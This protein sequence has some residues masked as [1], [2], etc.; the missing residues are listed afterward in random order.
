MPV[1]N[2]RRTA[3]RELSKK[4]VHFTRKN[5]D[6]WVYWTSGYKTMDHYTIG[7][8]LHSMGFIVRT[9]DFDQICGKTRSEFKIR[10]GK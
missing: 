6:T 9:E 5:E 10:G 8:Y 3:L 7:E 1:L 4:N 2:K